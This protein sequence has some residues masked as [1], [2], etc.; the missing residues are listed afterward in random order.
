[1]GNKKNTNLDA[2]VG[3]IG[4]APQ[5]ELFTYI[6]QKTNWNSK[7]DYINLSLSYSPNS[8][9]G[10]LMDT[11]NVD[12]WKQNQFI[13]K[14]KRNNGDI[15]FESELVGETKN[16]WTVGFATFNLSDE[17]SNTNYTPTDGKTQNVPLCLASDYPY[18]VGLVDKASSDTVVGYFNKGCTD[19]TKPES[20]PEKDFKKDK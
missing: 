1:M 15:T 2:S 9:A 18:M 5:S 4:L 6:Q 20:C 7:E 16:T 3:L 11:K 14:G 13:I 12:T 8:G 19:A 17:S 10:K